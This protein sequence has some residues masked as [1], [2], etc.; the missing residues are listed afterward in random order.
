MYRSSHQH[1]LWPSPSWPKVKQCPTKVWGRDWTEVGEV[2]SGLRGRMVRHRDVWVT[3]QIRLPRAAATNAP[4]IRWLK[5]AE[6]C[7][8]AALEAGLLQSHASRALV[9]VKQARESFSTTSWHL[10]VTLQTPMCISLITQCPPHAASY[11][12]MGRTGWEA[13]PTLQYDLFFV[14]YIFKDPT[15]K[16]IHILKVLG[17][18]VST[19]SWWEA[20]VSPNNWFSEM[21]NLR[22]LASLV[23]RVNLNPSAAT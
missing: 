20:Q 1:C 2:H 22:C 6:T 13:H 19:Y 11:K 7:G 5:T 8:P 14:T 12:V 17:S 18:R 3:P 23:K 4:H 21:E 16:D 15:S 9:P 10:E